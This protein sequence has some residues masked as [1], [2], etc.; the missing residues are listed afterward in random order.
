M[1][2]LNSEAESI[3]FLKKNTPSDK[4]SQVLNLT[5][6]FLIIIVLLNLLALT[7]AVSYYSKLFS[8]SADYLR[9]Y[10]YSPLYHRISLKPYQTTINGTIWPTTDRGPARRLPNL[11]DEAIWD[12]WEATDVIPITSSEIKAMGKDPATAAKLEDSSWN[13]GNDAYAGILDVFH[14]IHCLNQLRKF[15]YRDYYDMKIANA[16]PE[17]ETMHEIHTN[18]CTVEGEMGF[19]Q[20]L[21]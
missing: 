20:I 18:H 5:P 3:A 7:V 6:K 10:G 12:E 11:I 21:R 9:T 13:L 2:L 14:Q 17:Y 1:A 16:D 4:R 8:P 19:A 15:A